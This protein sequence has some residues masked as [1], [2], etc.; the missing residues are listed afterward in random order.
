[1]SEQVRKDQ[2][3]RMSPSVVFTEAYLKNQ[4]DGIKKKAAAATNE[5]LSAQASLHD[6]ELARQETEKQLN[7]TAGADRA[8]LKEKMMRNGA[9]RK[10]LTKKSIRFRNVYSN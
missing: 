4:L 7:A 5:F 3:A 9:Q 10:G 2:I 8:V 1:M 6:T